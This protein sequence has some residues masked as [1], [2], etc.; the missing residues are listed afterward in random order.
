M[1][2]LKQADVVMLT[3][4]LPEKFTHSQC[5]ANLSYYE[6]LTIHDSSL[7]QSV[8]AIVAARSGEV[9]SAY[10]FWRRGASIDLGSDAHSSDDGIHAAATGAIWSG[11]IQGFAG[12]TIVEGE[13]H[14]SPRLP[15]QWQRLQFS[16]MWRTAHLNIIV[17]NQ[18]LTVST[19]EPVTLTIWGKTL[20][21]LES[22]RFT[23]DDFNLAI[24]GTATTSG[25]A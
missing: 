7:S 17:E 1:Q 6:P 3:Y 5:F 4:L 21:I 25:E 13:L 20:T 10:Q 19:T 18:T 9:A 12:V 16:L 11:A 15:G 22:Q 2:I 8:H 23:N 24:N 14:L